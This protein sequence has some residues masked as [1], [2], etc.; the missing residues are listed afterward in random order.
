MATLGAQVGGCSLDY[1]SFEVQPDGSGAGGDGTGNASTGA[2]SSGAAGSGA[3]GSG[4]SSSGGSDAGGAGG[5]GD[6]GASSGGAS[7][8]GSGGSGGGPPMPGTVTY[9]AV[10]ARCTSYDNPNAANCEAQVDPGDMLVDTYE[11]NTGEPM[12]SFIR[13]DLDGVLVGKTVTAVTLRVRATTY[14]LGDSQDSGEIY[15]TVPFSLGDL[16]SVAPAQVG[17]LIGANQ[18]PVAHQQFVEW[19]LPAYLA[20]PNASLHLT[21]APVSSDL[22]TYYNDSMPDAP[23]LTVDYQ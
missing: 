14:A 17:G 15:Q 1:G 20:V 4:A 12:G 18:G 13:F 10:I 5:M 23:V 16:D 19:A 22:V 6:G 11:G 3:S 8:G 2:A 7:A 21:I 9:T